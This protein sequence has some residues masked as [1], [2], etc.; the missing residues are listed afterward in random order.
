M[1]HGAGVSPVWS[2]R[3]STPPGIIQG[4]SVPQDFIPKL[5]A[6][7]RAGQFPFDRLVRFYEFHEINRAIAD[8]RRGDTIKPVLRISQA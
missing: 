6:W 5:I 1:N 7:Y 8:A 4:D 3:G 2:G